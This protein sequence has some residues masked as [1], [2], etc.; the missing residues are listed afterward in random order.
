MGVD[1]LCEG[2][3]TL[4]RVPH[5]ACHQ[6]MGVAEG[7]ALRYQVLGEVDGR[8]ALGVGRVGHAFEVKAT[9]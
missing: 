8:N 4:E 1:E 7:N 3:V 2:D 9:R 6:P 5:E